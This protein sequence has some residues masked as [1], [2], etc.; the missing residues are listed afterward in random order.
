MFSQTRG[1]N[2]YQQ[3]GLETSVSGASPHALV[4]LLMD[5]SLAA[6]NIAKSKMAE[7]N[8]A[9]KGEAISKAIAL[10]DEGLRS[11]LDLNSGGEIAQNLE[12]LY[13]YMCHQLLMAN[14]K[15]DPERLDEVSRLMT[16]I[17]DAWKAIGDITPMQ[18]TT[19]STEETS[20]GTPR[21]YG[22]V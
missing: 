1:I 13:E 3:V 5:G 6:I 7:S 19:V 11:S 14:L 22:A 20:D 4:L 17:R 15:N 10:I 8:I 9:G 16:E 21:S 2:Q 18:P 12:A